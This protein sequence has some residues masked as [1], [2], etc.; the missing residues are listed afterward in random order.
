VTQ[1]NNIKKENVHMNTQIYSRRNVFGLL[2]LIL[3]LSSVGTALA[4]SGAVTNTLSFS[5][6]F[7]EKVVCVGSPLSCG[8]LDGD[9]FTISATVLLTGVNIATFGPSTSFDLTLGTLHVS[10]TLSDDPS[11][12]TGKT[13]AT[14]IASYVDGKGKTV[15]YRTVKLKW[16]AASL[17]VSVKGKIKDT[18]ASGWTSI[19][20]DAYADY[21]SGWLTNTITG[22]ISL[23]TANVTFDSVTCAGTVLTKQVTAKDGNPF[24]PSTVKI[25]GSGGGSVAHTTIPGVHVTLGTDTVVTNLTVG[26]LG[27]SVTFSG[28]PLNGVTVEVPVGALS[29]NV[30]LSLSHNNGSITPQS[31]TFPGQIIDLQVSGA[32]TNGTTFEEPI[33]ITIPFNNDGS[34]V[35]VPYY[36]DTNGFLRPCQVVSIDNET[37][38]LTFETFHASP[39]TWF[40]ASLTN[41]F[42]GLSATNATSYLPWVDG[43]QVGNPG[44]V[45]NPGGECFGITAFEQ[46]YFR[47]KGGGFYPKYMQNIPLGP[48]AGT[49]K[50]QEVIRTRA[51]NSVTRMWNSYLPGRTASY[52]LTPPQ[53][54]ASIC[55][56]LLNTHVPTI[57]STY[58]HSIL[59]YD[60]YSSAATNGAL[61]INDPNFPGTVRTLPYDP[62][63]TNVFTYGTYTNIALMGDGSFQMES[64]N[65]IYADAEDG[66]SGNGAAQVNITSHTDGAV[67]TTRNITVSGTI[68]SGQ[69]L[70]SELDIVLNGTTE[71][72]APVDAGGNFSV[73]LS[74]NAGTND[75]SF[76]TKGYVGLNRLVYVLNSQKQPFKLIANLDAAAILVT[77]T[78]NTDATDIDLYTTDPT[79]DCSWYSDHYT[80][81]GGEL[82]HDNTS[83]YGPE[84]WTLSYGDTVRWGSNYAVRVHYYSDHRACTNPSYCDPVVPVRPTGW[85]VTVLVYEN[86]PRMATYTFSGVLAD[87]KS[88]NASPGGSGSDWNSVCTITPVEATSPAPA[89][90]VRKT[91]KGEIEILVPMIQQHE[92]ELDTR[93]P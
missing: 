37:G 93:K 15:V 13:S 85:R 43:F 80:A 35:P 83:G 8:L 88:S 58:G 62:A 49:I 89:P 16:T 17:T 44:S 81:D 24:S 54:F 51:F 82:D 53:R 18:S 57:L 48:G 87:A 86:T 76:V 66:F 23:G 20:A 42:G 45:Y 27:G 61:L 39:Y 73:T 1:D 3:L 14:F 60:F 63:H 67:V 2:G 40:L 21:T 28:G 78:W 74:L 30:Q 41:L 75:L 64:F 92:L 65:D 19:L 91:S 25:K 10:H 33:A 46:W 84:H 90:S 38:H 70:V 29:S 36:I 5:E 26:S 79:G 72:V 69:V 77:L 9:T 52:N 71:F 68:D 32:P 6:S 4:S 22:S 7:S 11:Y 55:N 12:T 34:C 50:G 56:V 31:G 59:A 47:G